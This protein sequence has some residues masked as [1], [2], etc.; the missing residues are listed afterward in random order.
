MEGTSYGKDSTFT[1]KDFPN[2]AYSY[3][4]TLCIGDDV[5]FTNQ[6]T[7]SNGTLSY[8]WE[9]RNSNG[10]LVHSSTAISPTFTMSA[11]GTYT[12][13]LTASSSDAVTTTKT[14]GL[15]VE[16]TP[17][18]NITAGGATSFCQGGTVTLSGN[19]GYE[20]YAWSNGASTSTITVSDSNTYTMTVTSANGCEGSTSVNVDVNHYQQRR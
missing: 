13:K 8:D 3:D 14:T 18:P 9:I 7:I 17:T 6:S 12:V 5:S 10:S 20:S 16:A 1:T 19:T 15:V 4:S 11:A 2:R